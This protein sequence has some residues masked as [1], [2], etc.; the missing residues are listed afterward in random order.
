MTNLLLGGGNRLS[1]YQWTGKPLTT[2]SIAEG[3]AAGRYDFIMSA[4]L[5]PLISVVGINDKVVFVEKHGTQVNNNSSGSF[6]FDPTLAPQ[7][8]TAFRELRLKTDAFCSASLVLPDKAGRQINIGGW[9]VDSLYGVRLFTPELGLGKNGT[10]D[11]E[12][13]V[14]KLAL[15]DARWYPT[16]MT[17]SNGSIVVIGGENGSDGPI[18]P[19]CEILPRPSGVTKSTYL[20]YLKNAQTNSSYPF[21]AIL[22]SGD[23][24][25][26]QY[27]EA[28]LISQTDFQTTRMLPKMP[29][30]VNNPE[31]GRNYPLQGSMSLLPQSAPYTDPMTVL[32]CGGTT[33]G[34][35]FGLDNCISTQPEVPNAQW[36]IERMVSSTPST[37]LTLTQLFMIP[38]I[39]LLT[40]STS[41]LDPCRDMHGKPP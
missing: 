31:S 37:T 10:H 36:A 14:T 15:L 24:F 38:R 40:F 35:N 7:Y 8:G 39:L 12:E 28:R 20:D 30:A 11:W 17:L 22:P 23:I 1:Y 34:A 18:V 27:N 26:A 32:I 16:A 2:W 13:D 25:F 9:S 21:M 19:S 3:S 41:A 4:P 33:D 5:V 6:E 29:G